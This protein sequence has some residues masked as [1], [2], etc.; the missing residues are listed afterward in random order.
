MR[1]SCHR[2]VGRLLPGKLWRAGGGQADLGLARLPR[3]SA[4]GIFGSRVPAGARRCPP[5]SGRACPNCRRRSKPELSNDAELEQL[6][7]A[8]GRN[9]AGPCSNR[10]APTSTLPRFMPAFLRQFRRRGGAIETRAKVIRAERKGKRWSAGSKM[11]RRGPHRFSSTPRAPGPTRRACCGAAPLGIAPKRRTDGAAASRPLGPE[12]PAAGR[13]RRRQLL[14]QG[15]GRQSVWLSPHDEIAERSLRRSAGRNRCRDRDRP[16]R[17]GRRLAGR[18]GRTQ[19]GGSQELR[20]GPAAGL[21]IRCGGAGLFLVRR[22]G[23]IRHPDVTGRGE[24]GRSAVAWGEA[25]RSGRAHRT[26]RLLA[27]ALPR[28][29]KGGDDAAGRRLR[30]RRA[31]RP[32]RSRDGRCGP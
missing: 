7:P 3:R 10:A 31:R 32:G 25:A 9:G 22:A 20:A 15:R 13:C 14:L 30:R 18:G 28:L 6:C 17:A 4:E 27:G 16:L 2:P 21:R 24:I 8:S 5:N 29:I 23:R 19:L 26:R 12:R 11:A 1:L